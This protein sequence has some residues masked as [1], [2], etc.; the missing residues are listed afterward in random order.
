[1]DNITKFILAVIFLYPFFSYADVSIPGNLTVTGSVSLTGVTETATQSKFLYLK[2]ADNKIFVAPVEAGINVEGASTD[3]ILVYDGSDWISQATASLTSISIDATGYFSNVEITN[4]VTFSG[5]IFGH[6]IPTASATPTNVLAINA[7][8]KFEKFAF[9]SGG[10][11]TSTATY[12]SF[13]GKNQNLYGSTA[14]KIMRIS[15]VEQQINPAGL[16]TYADSSVNG[17]SF[18]MSA[19]CGT[20]GC[21]CFFSWCGARYTGSGIAYAGWSVNSSDLTQDI[22]SLTASQIGVQQSISGEAN[23]DGGMDACPTFSRVFSS[24]DVVRPQVGTSSGS[25]SQSVDKPRF[26][27]WCIKL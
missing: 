15:N 20:N 3:D 17:S 26:S 12:Y 18:T 23:S 24:G 11:A 10:S 25:P 1:M 4:D 2:S 8:G 16:V 13:H 19:A 6:D 7:G 21:L 5:N 27:A 14:T 9:P 22:F